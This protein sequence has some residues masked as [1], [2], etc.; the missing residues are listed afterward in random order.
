[1]TAYIKL[2]EGTIFVFEEAREY[3][4]IKTEKGHRDIRDD[5][6]NKV[7]N[8]MFGYTDVFPLRKVEFTETSEGEELWLISKDRKAA[9]GPLSVAATN[10]REYSDIFILDKQDIV[11]SPLQRTIDYVNGYEQA[12]EEAGQLCNKT[13]VKVRAAV[14]NLALTEKEAGLILT[15]LGTYRDDIRLMKPKG[16]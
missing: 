9:I 4:K 2:E 12:R 6:S 14:I 15:F 16:R 8:A 7:G 13:E 11:E 1:M 3:P 5:V 10:N